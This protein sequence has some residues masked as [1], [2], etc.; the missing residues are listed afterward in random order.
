MHH[1]R[2]SRILNGREIP[3]RGDARLIKV[4]EYINFRNFSI[5]FGT[6]EGKGIV[7]SLSFRV[8]FRKFFRQ[9]LLR[10]E[11]SS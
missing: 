7:L 4:A 10:Y 6:A 1:A 8:E 11:F 2:L 5:S 9:R 3:S